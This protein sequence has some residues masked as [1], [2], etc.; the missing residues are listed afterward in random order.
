MGIASRREAEGLIKNG[1]VTVDG[2]VAHLGMK[3]GLGSH[4]IKIKNKAVSLRSEVP[5][6]YWLLNK[7]DFTLVSKKG[8]QDKQTIFDLPS[9]RKV[10]FPLSA[11]GRLDYRTTGLLLLS[12]DGELIHR[13]TH[14]SYKVPRHYHALVPGKLTAEQLASVR[15]GLKLQDGV[16]SDVKITYLDSQ[17]LGK[18]SGSWY[19]VTVK[20]GRNRLVRRLFA[21]LDYKVLNL[22]RVGY[23][24]LQLPRQLEPGKYQQLTSREVSYLKRAVRL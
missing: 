20:E 19:L 18:T 22:I 3:V 1:H 2:E 23:G 14:P 8:E 24:D 15:S 5:K 4:N 21:H 17:N 6:V 12:N 9:L 10:P 16:V 13:L 11:A 7:P